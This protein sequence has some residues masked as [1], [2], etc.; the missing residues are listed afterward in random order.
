[1]NILVGRLIASGS[2]DTTVRIWETQTG[3]CLH[4]MTE[5]TEKVWEVV[6]NKNASHLASCSEDKTIKIWDTKTGLCVKTLGDA[7]CV[8]SLAFR[9]DDILASGLGKICESEKT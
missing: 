9:F 2:W 5:H 6:L 3:E 1:M 8:Y 7:D 4:I